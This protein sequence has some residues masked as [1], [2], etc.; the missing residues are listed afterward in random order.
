MIHLKVA[1]SEAF[2]QLLLCLLRE[3]EREE[4]MKRCG[5]SRKGWCKMNENN[6]SNSRYQEPKKTGSEAN[7]T[8]RTFSQQLMEK[9]EKNQGKIESLIKS[10]T[11]D[12]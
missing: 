5:I 2:K 9:A 6:N 11:K 8:L 7:E 12:K 3:V 1:P 4:R 10:S